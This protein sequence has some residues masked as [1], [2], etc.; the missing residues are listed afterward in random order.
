V[1]IGVTVTRSNSDLDC[2]E[3]AN[4]GP[5]MLDSLHSSIVRL[6]K[7]RSLLEMLNN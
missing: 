6:T 3:W 1:V 2:I 5:L 4:G 7:P